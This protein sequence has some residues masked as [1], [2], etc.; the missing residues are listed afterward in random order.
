[1]EDLLLGF[2]KLRSGESTKIFGAVD[3]ALFLALTETIT[4]WPLNKQT[5][6]I[7]GGLSACPWQG[8]GPVSMRVK[9]G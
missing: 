9:S 8:V 7:S 4:N 3:P 2:L 1:M 6:T 5:E